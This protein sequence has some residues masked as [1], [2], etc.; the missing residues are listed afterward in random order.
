VQGPP[1]RSVLATDPPAGQILPF[2][3]PVVIATSL[4]AG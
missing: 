1:D 2:G 3:T 4:T